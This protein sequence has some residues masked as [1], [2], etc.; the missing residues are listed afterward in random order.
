MLTPFLP[1]ELWPIQDPHLVTG[2]LARSPGL[3]RASV[4]RRN[5]SSNSKCS[6][7][8]TN[9]PWQCHGRSTGT[10]LQPCNWRSDHSFP[11]ADLVLI[12]TSGSTLIPRTTENGLPG[13]QMCVGQDCLR[14]RMAHITMK[15]FGL[16]IAFAAKQ[17]RRV[18]RKI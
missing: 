10:H 16:S 15:Q 2:F 9:Q 14:I 18:Q 17:P 4:L 7:L 5:C 1:I 8:R 3:F 12:G 6:C 11:A 13:C